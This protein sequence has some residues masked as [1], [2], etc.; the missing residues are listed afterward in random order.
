[1]LQTAR[2]YKAT[3]AYNTYKKHVPAPYLRQKITLRAGC[4]CRLYVSG[5]GFYELYVNGKN[6]TKGPLAPYISNPDDLVYFDAYDLRAHVGAAETAVIGLLLG[7]GMQNAPGGRV[8]DFDAARFRNA[9]CFAAVLVCTDENGNETTEDI[10]ARFRTHPSPI[11]FDDLR[12]GC[13]YD[14]NK[15]IPGWNMPDF[16]DRDWTPVLPADQP[17]G[18]RRLCEADP[19]VITEELK[20][21]AVRQAKLDT[22]FNNRKNMRLRTEYRPRYRGK[23]GV[24]FDFGVNTAGLCRLR[25]NGKKGQKIFIQ[26]CEHLTADGKPSYLNTGSFY[27]DGYGQTVLYICKGEPDETFVPSFCYFGYRYAIVFGLKATQYGDETLTLLRANSDLKERGSFACSDETMNAL[28]SLTR[29]S[30]LAN[31]WYFPTDCPHRE[32]NGWTGDA[33]VSAEHMLLTLTPEKSYREWLRNICKAQRADGALPGIIPTGGWGFEWGNG[34]AWDN[35]LSELCWQIARLRGDLTPAAESAAALGK[36]LTYLS[37]LRDGNGLISYGLGDW[38]QP[39]RSAGDP[40]APTL[41]TSSVIGMYIAAKSA[42]LFGRLDMPEQKAYAVSL[43]SELRQ[44]VRAHFIDFET[45]T[46][47]PRCQTAQA[48]CIYYGVFEETEKAA[49]G[50]VLETIVHERGDHIDCGMLGLRVIFHVL[51]DLGYGGLAYRMIT[52]TDYPSYGMFVRRGYTSLPENFVPDSEID[53]PSSLNHHFF[54]DI[55]SWFMQRV[56]GVCVNPDDTDPN[57]ILLRPDF[58]EALTFAEAHYDAP[59][60][61]VTARWE[62]TDGGVLLKTQAPDAAKGTVRLPAGYALQDG[63]SVFPLASGTFECVKIKE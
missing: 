53:E 24:L 4:G 9:P 27:P 56:V 13:F 2:F 26:F 29:V 48:M 49:A 40:V 50:K 6:V 1:M 30:D 11:L 60:G 21:V 15:E 61:R 52:R 37:G 18:E 17:R 39:D 20:P 25:I 62:K 38:L 45:M 63:A 12:S 14:A 44:A 10:G 54:G 57:T 55:V 34:P 42:A 23:K 36:Y 41:L 28:G 19:I 47:S 43:R 58:L 33:A 3:N 5:L 16:D 35:V 51:S 8:W 59:C 7:N 32:K 31:F 22:R 46:V